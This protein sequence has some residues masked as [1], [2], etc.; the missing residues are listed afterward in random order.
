MMAFE[1]NVI[2]QAETAVVDE[3]VQAIDKS[4]PKHPDSKDLA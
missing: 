2:W 3:A 4:T 1:V